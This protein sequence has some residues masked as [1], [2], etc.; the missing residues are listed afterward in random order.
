LQ[1]PDGS[2]AERIANGN[3]ATPIPPLVGREPIAVTLADLNADDLPDIIT[4]SSQSDNAS[5]VLSTTFRRLTVL[6]NHGE[7][8]GQTMCCFVRFI[9]QLLLIKKRCDLQ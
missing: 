1:N 4:T 7:L 3:S 6:P 8:V 9:P 5:F 2:F